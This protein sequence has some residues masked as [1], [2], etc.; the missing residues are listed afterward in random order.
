MAIDE[1]KMMQSMYDTLFGA[2]T[3]TPPGGL[4]AGSQENQMFISM[5]PGGQPVD[6]QL[7]ANPRSPLN[8]QGIPAA[9][10]NFSRL[11]DHLPLVKATYVDSSKRVS[12]VYRAVVEGAN[13]TPQPENPAL[14]AAY[15]KAYDLLTD[16][17]DDFDEQGKP[18]KI[19]GDSPLYANYKRKMNAYSDAVANFMAEASK[20]DMKKPEDQR[21]WA[22]IGPS[23]QKM[24][25]TAW[26]D[27]Q[28]AQAK[29]VE[30]ALATVA[31]SAENQ[32]GRVFT[33]TQERLTLLEKGSVMDQ[34]DK[35]LPTYAS[36]ANWYSSRAAE[37]WTSL[38]FSSAKY[39]LNQSSSY[40]SYGGSAGFS[41]G[42]FSV[43]GSASHSTERHH[44]DSETSNLSVSFRYARINLER[45]WFNGLIFDLPGWTYGPVQ[46][47]G[48][49][50][51]N[52]DTSAN[53][54]LTIVPTGFIVVRDLKI[55]ANWGKQDAD[56]IKKA[57]SGGGSFG[58]GPFSIGGSYQS[59]S[60]ES[61]FQSEFDGRTL[62][63][64]GLQIM[65]FISTV[66]PF[67]PK[68]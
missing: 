5:I 21:A 20:Y 67:A 36:P 43:G 16:E 48:V 51:G 59:G 42:L 39:Q 31:Q 33:D 12:D 25:T 30:D 63:A 8:P 32:V 1:A 62:S 65:A 2:Y 47:G 57:T 41:M 37:G 6:V 11:V 58:W 22:I 53:T 50:S 35:Y 4:R 19:P 26:N 68:A 44:M 40:V 64:P 27:F 38:T 56:S 45:P 55:S 34:M 52:P 29:K 61:N 15:N 17:F 23:K 28:T 60:S 14:K 49:S 66:M 24:L 18:T 54:L 7:Y 13:I 3:N 46:K 10:E 9:T